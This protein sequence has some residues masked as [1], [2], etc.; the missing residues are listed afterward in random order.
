M[1]GMYLLLHVIAHGEQ[2]D[3]SV[4]AEDNAVLDS[5]FI[6]IAEVWKEDCREALFSVRPT[7]LDCVH[8]ATQ[9]VIGLSSCA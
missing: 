2:N 4:T 9:C 3:N 5:E 7:G 8:E 1:S 6:P